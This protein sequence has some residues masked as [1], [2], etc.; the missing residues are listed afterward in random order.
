MRAL[1]RSPNAWIAALAIALALLFL[2]SRGIWD[3]D[4]GRYTNVALHMLDSGDWL[5]PHRSDAVNHWTKPPL[6]Y[7]A[8]ASGIAVFGH[9]PAAARLPAA[10]SYLLCVWLAWRIARRLAPGVEAQAALVYATMLLP[11]G[12]AQFITTDYPLAA[13]E[14]LAMWGFVEARFGSGKSRWL[15][16]TWA[17]FGLA[18]LTK[19]PPGLLPLLAV[20]AFDLAMPGRVRPRLLQWWSLPLFLLV[21]APWY[22]AVMWRNPGLLDYLIGN[23]VVDRIATD[24]FA[25]Y[26]QWYGWIVV[27]LPTL[28][29][30]TLPWTPALLRWARG[31]P[32]S[33]R[34]WRTPANRIGDG[35]GLLLALWLLLPL[36]V[37]CVSRS[38][39][40]LYILPLF[41]PLAVL[42]ARQRRLEGK[43]LPRWRWL[44]LWAV[45]LLALKLAAAQW[46][47]HKD[48]RAWAEAIR[49]RAPGPISQVEI[50][51]DMARYGLHLH[52][53]AQVEK[54]SLQAQ[55]QSRFNPEHD[56]NV[57]AALG[58]FDP[59]AL[60]ITKQAH[61]PQVR[62]AIRA[63]QGF[64][65][66]PQGGPYRQR[67]IFRV[68]RTGNPESTF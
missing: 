45:C 18:F 2:G 8:I 61:W 63:Q 56:G 37:F 52:L 10:L 55:P 20:V 48:A 67:I 64:A 31:L 40:P 43:S 38:R 34:K 5:Q 60:W 62:D 22:A 23:E 47:T 24:H 68:R 39:L 26:G 30:G 14:T 65:A 25:R 57:A 66:I 27:Y 33:V 21:A 4:E 16:L 54:L 29:L 58:D 41:V 51:E 6:T 50:V 1:L 15:M 9:N 46:P 19:G 36:L 42:A 13:C 12:T 35:A 3:P 28:L 17:G 44:L 32:A 7:W 11:F 59:D 53:R 49:A